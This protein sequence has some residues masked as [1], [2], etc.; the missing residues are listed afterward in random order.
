MLSVQNYGIVESA[1]DG[2]YWEIKEEY[3]S[4]VLSHIIIKI[5]D[6]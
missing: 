4:V 5:T 3:F 1:I 2:N 6:N